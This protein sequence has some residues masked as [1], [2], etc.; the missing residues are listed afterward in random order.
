MDTSSRKDPSKQRNV[1]IGI[2]A[3][4]G[5]VAVILIRVLSKDKT[6]DFLGQLGGLILIVTGTIS[7]LSFSYKTTP[8]YENK[9]W[10]KGE[11]KR[12]ERVDRAGW[13]C[14]GTSLTTLVVNA[15]WALAENDFRPWSIA[16]LV[17]W[18]VLFFPGMG[19]MRFLECK[20][21]N[22][23][24]DENKS[25]AVTK[26]DAQAALDAAGRAIDQAVADLIAARENLD[27]AN[28]E[29]NAAKKALEQA[30]TDHPS[31]PDTPDQPSRPDLPSEPD[32]PT[33]PDT[34]SKPDRPSKLDQPS[35][36]DELSKPNQSDQPVQPSEPRQAT[37][38][39][40]SPADSTE[41]RVENGVALQK[42]VK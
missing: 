7:I 35:D 31:K 36:S 24:K 6:G 30:K 20:C 25:G 5:L 21:K 10:D 27:R 11:Q 33:Q 23:S 4:V 32:Q 41:V 29:L 38:V 22:K 3:F 37:T 19:G 8:M 17:V 12:S 42:A 28:D 9:D 18:L 15:V 34:P 16:N 2:G 39:K 40:D 13:L 14:T 26:T 1:C